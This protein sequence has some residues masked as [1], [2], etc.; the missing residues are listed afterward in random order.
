MIHTHSGRIQLRILIPLAVL[1]VAAVTGG[2][3]YAVAEMQK[4]GSGNEISKS[5]VA[6]TAPAGAAGVVGFPVRLTIPKI[7][8]DSGFQYTGVKPDGGMEI[9]DNVTD[10]S[11]YKNSPRPGEEGTSII[12]GHFVQVRGGKVTKPGVFADLDKLVAGD[13]L[14]VEDNRGTS[15]AFVVREVRRYDPEADATDVFTSNDG[16]HLN[17]ITCAGVWNPDKKS[18]S[19]R[20]V[21]FTEREAE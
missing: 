18:Y 11:W 5:R 10:V 4:A 9:P 15:I 1:V 20:L 19:E 8:A 3:Y 16:N 13:K 14:Y 12:T 21:I 6:G 7:K 2:G 17:I